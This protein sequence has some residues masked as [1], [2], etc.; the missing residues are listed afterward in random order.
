MLSNQ[1][2]EQLV[3]DL[4]IPESGWQLVEKAR[5]DAPV[6]QVRST[7]KNVITLIASRK[8][9]R[10]I[11]TESRTV[12]YKAALSHEMNQQVLEYY[13][14]PCTVKLELIDPE[15]GEVHPIDHTPD[16]L[17]IQDDRFVLQ[18]WK[19][20]E[21]LLQLARRQ[22][23]RYQKEEGRWRSTQIEAHLASMGI[24]YEVRS[25]AEIHPNR[26]KNLEVLQDYLHVGAPERPSQA[27]IRLQ[28]AL[29]EHGRLSF[30]DLLSDP[31][32]FSA[33]DLNLAIVRALVACDLD[34][35][36]LSTPHDFL[37]YRDEALMT[38][39]RASQVGIR[40]DLSS[41]FSL[42]LEP[43]ARFQFEGQTLEVRLLA[44]KEVTF[45]CFETDRDV[46]LNKDWLLS[47]F[48]GGKL[49]QL[50]V[51]AA[52][53]VDVSPLVQYS[54]EALECARQR[55]RFLEMPFD[56]LTAPFSER[57]F[58][59]YQERQQ[60]GVMNGCHE[61]LALVPQHSEKG[62]RTP[63]LSTEQV[64]AMEHVR[65]TC[66][67]SHKS[68][69]GK[70]AYRELCVYCSTHDIACPSYPT[71]L[72]HLKSHE[73]NASRKVR[74]GKRMAYQNEQFYYSLAYDTP[75]HGVRPFECVHVDH[76]LLDIELKCR[77][78][79]LSLGRPWLTM[80]VDAFSRRIMALHLGFSQPDRTAVMMVLRAF[81]KRW[82]RM[83]QMLMSDNGKDLIA[84]DVKHF[85]GNLGVHF[86]LRP[87]GQP[88]VG[89][90]MERLFGTLN[91]QLLHNLEGNTE[92][93][94]HVR[95]LSGSHLPK[96]LANWN[97]E[98][99]YTVL[100]AWAF[101]FYDQQV[102]PALDISPRAAF[103]K[104]IQETGERAHRMITFNRDFLVA[105]C[106][107]VDRGGERKIDR[108]RGVK[109]HGFYYQ[110]PDFDSYQIAGKKFAVRYD[111]HDVGRVFV[112]LPNR[113][114]VEAH[115]MSLMHLPRMN[116]RQL[117][118][119]TAEYMTVHSARMPR[120]DSISGTQLLEFIATMSPDADVFRQARSLGETEYLHSKLGLLDP[121]GEGGR[122]K[123]FGLEPLQAFAQ[124]QTSG[125]A[126]LNK[127][128]KH[129]SPLVTRTGNTVSETET[130]D[131]FTRRKPLDFDL[132]NYRELDK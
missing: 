11:A 75:R 69:N 34:E 54:S 66:Y 95:M 48:E 16:F 42:N 110:C 33:D 28:A 76:T 90:V 120:S 63:R 104:A 72:N 52:S 99:L 13:P 10:E 1:Q 8:M 78:T 68:P 25:G 112:Q 60:V 2:F 55:A 128:P 107:S 124:A 83:P 97:L 62:N 74:N 5:R 102:H 51:N 132:S 12:E 35:S 92:L 40:N 31:F 22:P 9:G 67:V 127:P 32:S 43:G 111:P 108:Q 86:R 115:C 27:L 64:N 79:G 106:P 20:E 38:F 21:K 26:L 3:L 73:T 57:T 80:V 101:E 23:W 19:T 58:Y 77:R 130:P 119:I 89:S 61:I 47:A 100:E 71:F 87:A 56:P 49:R 70:S 29:T 85:L 129:V 14:Q 82:G 126:L 41:Q 53:V 84:N 109:V 17:V 39:Y 30:G 50:S 131:G 118:A 44:E 36:L 98:N 96:K 113:G 91:T 7:G 125:H 18:E 37:L 105:T 4:G 94:K 15:T 46:S 116:V 103:Q 122:P 121:P 65:K 81:V 93:T 6:R 88:R 117:E 59:R 45:R 114:W 24:I 123:V